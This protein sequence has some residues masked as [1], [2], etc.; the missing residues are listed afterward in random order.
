[1]KKQFGLKHKLI[2]AVIGVASLFILFAT[3]AGSS[4]SKLEKELDYYAH[5]GV[6]ITETLGK[7]ETATNAIPR[8]VWLSLAYSKDS[9]ERNKALSNIKKYQSMLKEKVQYIV[10]HTSESETLDKVKALHEQIEP[11]YVI[12]DQGSYLIENGS[13]QAARDLLINGM[14]FFALRLSNYTK[15]LLDYYHL[16]NE[17]IEKQAEDIIKNSKTIFKVIFLF[18]LFLVVTFGFKFV[19]TLTKHLTEFTSKL[20]ESSNVL[21]FATNKLSI[22]S[23]GITDS[24]TK[25]SSAIEKTAAAVEQ[26]SSMVKQTSDA[27]ESVMQLSESSK[28]IAIQGKNIVEMMIQAMDEIRNNN[29]QMVDQSNENNLKF[30]QVLD[31]IKEIEV[32][33]KVI[34]DIVFQTKLLSFNASVEAARAGEMGKGFA[35]VAEEVGNLAQ[36]SGNAARDI[37]VLL[38]ESVNNT[39]KVLKE[40]Q[41][42]ILFSVNNGKE[43]VSKGIEISRECGELLN[44]IVDASTKVTEMVSSVAMAGKEQTHGIS[45]I[46]VAIHDLNKSINENNNSAKIS[47]QMS[48]KLFDETRG[49]RDSTGVLKKEIDGK[50]LVS[51]FKWSSDFNLNV[52]A[53][54]SEHINLVNKINIFADCLDSDVYSEKSVQAFNDLANTAIKHFENEEKFMQ[55]FNFIEFVPHKK[56]H[57]K[58]IS[59]VLEVGENLKRK[60]IDPSAVMNFLNDWLVGHILGQDMKYAIQ[61]HNG[62]AQGRYDTELSK[63]AA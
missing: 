31:T 22:S 56:I 39:E 45:D 57:E 18:S 40:T 62:Q 23:K 41:E 36:M 8:F 63:L 25:Q 50:P 4:I 15:E 44:K 28:N 46:S 30:K 60:N 54:D 19:K 58:L 48:V 33:T 61:Y 17:K 35:V 12:V 3:I 29:Q 14:P 53:M 9:D 49:L 11:L 16:N 1:M 52:N 24:S 51:K 37:T 32:K 27:T 13:D 59:G 47:Q 10:E 34:N 43:K 55:S 21:T 42:S 20:G 38:S 6:P 7:I 2:F 5:V 26:I